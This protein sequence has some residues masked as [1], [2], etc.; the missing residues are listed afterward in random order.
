MK[1]PTK[2]IEPVIIENKWWEQYEELNSYLFTH[3]NSARGKG[4][5]EIYYLSDDE[6]L[7]PVKNYSKSD[8][9]SVFGYTLNPPLFPSYL[10][11]DIQYVGIMFENVET[12]EKVWFHF[13]R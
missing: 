2:L 9:Y 10:N 1:S 4:C 7:V 3:E 11:G 13:C 8:E 5:S 6:K 12:F